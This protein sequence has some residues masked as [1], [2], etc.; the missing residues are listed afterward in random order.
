MSR[1]KKKE[2]LGEVKVN[3]QGL[4]MEIIEY[5]S[6]KDMVVMFPATGQ[7]R[8]ARYANFAKGEVYAD[9]QRYPILVE[10]IKIPTL[11]KIGLTVGLL[12][13]AT[14]VITIISIFSRG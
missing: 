11:G 9:L 1:S 4:D 7:K 12:A 8:K 6:N 14:I 2:R 5:H 13:L 3:R 10:G